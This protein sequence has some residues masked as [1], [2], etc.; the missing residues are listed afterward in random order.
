MVSEGTLCKAYDR[1]G[2]KGRGGWVEYL[3]ARRKDA[4]RLHNHHRLA[5][6]SYEGMSMMD[7]GRDSVTGDVMK[8]RLARCVGAY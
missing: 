8:V 5:A 2:R 3:R 6:T 1:K 4:L 7:E